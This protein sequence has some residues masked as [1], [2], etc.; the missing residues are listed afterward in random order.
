MSNRGELDPVGPAGVETTATAPSPKRAHDAIDLERFETLCAGG[1]LAI[2]VEIERLVFRVGLFNSGGRRGQLAAIHDA[3]AGVPWLT[4]LRFSAAL[5]FLGAELHRQERRL[6]AE[7]EHSRASFER[8]SPARVAELQ[9]LV[10]DLADSEAELTG[11]ERHA[12]SAYMEPD[13]SG[14]INRGLRGTKPMTDDTYHQC[15]DMITGIRKL[16]CVDERYS[17]WR[18]ASLF[19]G[20]AGAADLR[21]GDVYTEPA[22]VSS[23]AERGGLFPG[24]YVLRIDAPRG[25]RDVTEYGTGPTNEH[26]QEVLFLPGTSFVYR[27]CEDE[28]YVFE[29]LPAPKSVIDR[30]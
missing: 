8:C 21:V 27:G 23:S 25:G 16:P 9:R 17:V 4:Q 3:I 18:G 12:I 7:A 22:F 24:G 19:F 29:A 13:G 20:G 11:E 26:E 2:P 5:T 14:H 30:D 6:D 28:V 10:R 15:R 1:L